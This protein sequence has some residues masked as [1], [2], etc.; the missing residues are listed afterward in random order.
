MLQA[1]SK[2]AAHADIV[3]TLSER[4]AVGLSCGGE[5][6]FSAAYPP[7]EL[8]DTIGAGDTFN[9]A[10]IDAALRGKSLSASL[11]HACRLAGAKCGQVGFH[12]LDRS[13]MSD[14]DD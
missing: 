5:L 14:G 2:N 7:A 10:M 1:A 9:A 3:C 13:R 11:A 8:V 6:V 12:G 4:G